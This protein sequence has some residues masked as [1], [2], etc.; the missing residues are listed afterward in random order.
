MASLGDEIRSILN[1]DHEAL[2]QPISLDEVCSIVWSLHPE[3][4]SGLDG[5]PI[6]FY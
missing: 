2:I 6:G 5:F 1:E 3:K 4:G